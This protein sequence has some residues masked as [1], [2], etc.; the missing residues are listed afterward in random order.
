[1]ETEAVSDCPLVPEMKGQGPK[2]AP[3]QSP[4]SPGLVGAGREGAMAEPEQAVQEAAVAVGRRPVRA[5][6]RLAR[7]CPRDKETPWLWGGCATPTLKR[8]H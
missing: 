7:A 4:C 8:G 2:E 3:T 6:R 1:M 5:V